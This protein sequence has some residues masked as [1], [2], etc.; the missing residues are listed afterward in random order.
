MY[1]KRF[2]GERVRRYTD[3]MARVLYDAY[4]KIDKNRE[5][6]GLPSPAPEEVDILSWPQTWPDANCG[7]EEPL[8]NV[9]PSEQ[10]DVVMDSRTD[11]V[12]VYH[13]GVF[14]RHVEHPGP[15]FWEAVRERCLPGQADREAWKRLLR[16]EAAES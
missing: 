4:M 3:K 7:F 13:A 14:V 10:T 8:H 12:Y 6:R 2:Y 1:E 9:F 11:T 15:G 16:R 5:A